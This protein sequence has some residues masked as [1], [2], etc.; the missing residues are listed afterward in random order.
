MDI[1]KRAP[2][3][4]SATSRTAASGGASRREGV[5]RTE[6]PAWFERA[7]GW[8]A[9]GTLL[10]AL[11]PLLVGNAGPVGDARLFHLP[12]QMLVGDFARAGELLLWNP[13]TNGG[14]PDGVEPQI[15]A[16]SPLAVGSGLLAGGSSWSFVLFWLGTWCLSALG[17]VRLVRHLGAPAWA[18]YGIAL[19]WCANGAFVG[20]AGHTCF[21]HAFAFLP[22]SVWCLD[23]ALSSA[24]VAARLRLAASAGAWWGLSALAG[25]PGLVVVCALVLVGW[26]LVRMLPAALGEE[27]RASLRAVALAL[28]VW[29]VTGLVVLAPSYVGFFAEGSGFSGRTDTLTRE[30]ATGWGAE[31]PAEA[32]PLEPLALF[33]LANSVIAPAAARV[34]E[35]DP[36]PVT[37]ATSV[38][39]NAGLAAWVL[40]FIALFGAARS[41][42]NTA[43][44]AL[45]LLSLG[46]ALGHTLP[47]R[48]W[49]YDLLPPLRYFRHSAFFRVGLL[50]VVAVLAAR[51]A[52]RVD[53]RGAARAALAVGLVAGLAT[54]TALAVLPQLTS[55]TPLALF[56]VPPVAILAL[57]YSARLGERAMRRTLA[58]VTAGGAVFALLVGRPLMMED[59][60]RRDRLDER[61][62][63]ELDDNAG[64]ERV[65]FAF[66]IPEA[67]TD[68]LLAGET[69]ALAPYFDKPVRTLFDSANLPEKSNVLAGYTALNSARHHQFAAF[70]VLMD[71]ALGRERVFFAAEALHLPDDDATFATFAESTAAGTVPLVVHTA[72][73]PWTEVGD[74]ATA[75]IAAA[76][77]ERVP[78]DL[79]RFEPTS[80]ELELARPAPQDGWILVTERWARGWSATVRTPGGV[81]QPT[82]VERAGF[83]WRAVRV[84]EGATS[85]RFR[86]APFGWP[87]LLIVSWGTL[88]ALLVG[89]LR[90]KRGSRTAHV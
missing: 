35:T 38:G 77:L 72:D 6:R 84:P 54:A 33:T 51:G 58:V 78:F 74:D 16:F 75:R 26:A 87:W 45:G 30:I 46:L 42:R 88:L 17:M 14:S 21:V 19:A 36:F 53:A 3:S 40:T 49:A 4:P 60:A 79:V 27:P 28:G 67:R 41:R 83:L 52:S 61:R 11:W 34:P 2:P 62:H 13:W 76:R 12:Y 55:R 8:L 43:L 73:E 65:P 23:R 7:A 20:H 82:P 56:A 70:P 37:D 29:L 90:A 25:Y 57:A 22:W 39:V 48:A 64:F 63:A 81:D 1:D 9:A 59:T 47:L 15:G 89:S 69:E 5:A 18:Q 68:Q 66:T 85:V 50:F 71:Q 24:S 10:V 31:D 86:Y 32:N 80:L 44:F